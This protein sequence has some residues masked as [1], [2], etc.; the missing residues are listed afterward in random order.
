MTCASCVSHVEKSLQKIK[1][2]YGVLVGLM[3]ERAEVKIDPKQVDENKFIECINSLG[4]KAEIMEESKG[5]VDVLN[6]N[7]RKSH[8]IKLVNNFIYLD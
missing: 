7:V 1:G 2:V 8:L 6:L 5:G 3:I 4:Y